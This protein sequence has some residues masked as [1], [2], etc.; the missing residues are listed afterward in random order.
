MRADMTP[1][2]AYE[3]L[4]RLIKGKWWT[5]TETTVEAEGKVRFRGFFGQYEV[6]VR[7]GRRELTGTFRFDKSRREIMDVRLKNA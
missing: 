5:Q 3:Q 2:P 7:I 4:H 6:A 1:K